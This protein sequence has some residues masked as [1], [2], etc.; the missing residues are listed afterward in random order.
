MDS[1]GAQ[2]PPERVYICGPHAGAGGTRAVRD[3]ATHLAELVA[4]LP[5]ASPP[6]PYTN[7]H[8]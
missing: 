8:W 1:Y 7:L 6:I 3:W 4:E 5:P 2:L